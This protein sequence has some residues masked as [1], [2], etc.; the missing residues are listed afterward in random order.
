VSFTLD[1]AG[2]LVPRLDAA[3][4]LLA[5]LGFTLTRRAEHRAESGGSA[6]SAQCSIMLEAGYVEVQEI[7]GLAASTHILA[8]AARRNF[9]LHTLAFDVP[10]AEAARAAVAQAGLAVTPVMHWAR[11]VQE[12]DIEAEAR[13]AFFVAA[14]DPSEE[15]LLCWVQHLTP[16]ALRSPRLLRHANGARALA[17][18]VI[19]TRGDPAALVARYVACG[20]SAATPGMV[21]FGQGAVE[22]RGVADL[23]PILVDRPWP[24]GSWFAALRIVFDD[25]AA[26]ADVAR[27][28]G[29]VATPWDGGLVVDLRAPLGCVVIA[30]EPAAAPRR[31]G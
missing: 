13:F 14:Y 20:G 17:S 8:P 5:R 18:V 2:I 11:A 4:A 21:S 6:G 23:P 30:Q 19:A 10:D 16:A 9:G 22:I 3:A 31:R 1:H 28:E 15:A 26:F 25:P 24:A 12:V 29:F 7:A 27:R